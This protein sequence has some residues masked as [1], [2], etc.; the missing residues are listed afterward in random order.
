MS[1]IVQEWVDRAES[2]YRV[3]CRESQVDVDPSYDAVCFHA[4]Q[5]IEKLMKAV[6]IDRGQTPPRTHDLL[7]L[8]SLL[9]V[10]VPTW[11]WPSSELSTLTAAAVG[12]RYPGD[13]AEHED[14]DDMLEICTRLRTSLL[15][16][17]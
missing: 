10:V 9:V 2:D 5:C 15:A 14:A 4:Q 13:P 8:A 1:G 12:F 16:L 6:L 3:A 7:A 11:T 17:L